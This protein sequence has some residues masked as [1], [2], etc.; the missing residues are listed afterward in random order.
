[1]GLP[2][3]EVI[4]LLGGEGYPTRFGWLNAV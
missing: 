3:Y 2:L 4:T 1:V